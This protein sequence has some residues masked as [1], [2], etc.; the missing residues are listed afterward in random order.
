LEFSEAEDGGLVRV[1]LLLTKLAGFV[2]MTGENGKGDSEEE[3]EWD[4]G[5][6]RSDMLVNRGIWDDG[7]GMG[8]PCVEREFDDGRIRTDVDGEEAEDED[9]D[10]LC[11]GCE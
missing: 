4:N 11:V 7:R 1:V 6:V 10:L 5:V 9:C 8:T 3:G 2:D